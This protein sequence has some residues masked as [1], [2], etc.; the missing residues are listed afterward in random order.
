MLLKG[1][2]ASEDPFLQTPPRVGPKLCL[3]RVRYAYPRSLDR[4]FGSGLGGDFGSRY[5]KKRTRRPFRKGVRK[6]VRSQFPE[7]SQNEFKNAFTTSDSIRKH[8]RVLA[9][10]PVVAQVAH[11]QVRFE[12]TRGRIHPRDSARNEFRQSTIGLI[13]NQLRVA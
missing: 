8:M 10:N 7:T 13:G 1:G 5:G 11:G 12:R 6:G 4:V 3:V 2:S 9:A